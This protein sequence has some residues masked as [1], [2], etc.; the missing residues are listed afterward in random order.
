MFWDI[1]IVAGIIWII[2]SFFGF[3]QNIKVKNIFTI[4]EKSGSVYFGRDAGLLR[5][6]YITFV[7]VNPTGNVV[8]AMKLKATRFVTVPK[9]FQFSELQGANLNTLEPSSLGLDDRTTAS[10]TDLIKNYKK[11]S[12]RKNKKN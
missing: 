5:T 12:S 11:Y 7:A 10:I 2:I 1:I 9:V 6:K 3:L 4:L 8:E